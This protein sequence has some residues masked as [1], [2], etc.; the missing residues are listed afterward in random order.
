MKTSKITG[1]KE[2]AEKTINLFTGDCANGCIYCYASANNKRFNKPSDKVLKKNILHHNFK[3]R[4]YLT[5]Y[6]STHDIRFE[7]IDLHVQFLHNFLKSG[8]Q[9]LIV[10]KPSLLAIDR[11]CQELK[12]YQ[13][14]I[15]FRFTVGSSNSVTLGFFEPNAPRYSERYAAVIRASTLGYR[16]SLSIEPMLDQNPERIIEDVK[17]FITG[18]IWVGKMNQ[19]KARLKLNGNEDKLSKVMELA[20]WQANDKNILGI[21]KK[22]SKYPNVRWKDSI[23]EVISL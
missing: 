13:A 10:T 6:P 17:D 11:L 9:I 23:Q 12:P 1:T 7:D 16:V 18:D 8:S 5:M 15:E 2:W 19:P 21:V 4:E 20:E 3:K 22:L 14:Q